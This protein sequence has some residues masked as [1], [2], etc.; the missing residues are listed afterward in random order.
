MKKILLLDVDGTLIHDR[1]YRHAMVAAAQHVCR[2]RALPTHAPTDHE[3]NA[4]HACGFS[5][6]WDS[7]PFTVGINLLLAAN[8]D[9]APPDFAAWAIKTK[10]FAGLPN[11][12]A[13]EALKREAPAK[14]HDDLHAL[15]DEVKDPHTSETTRLLY[16]FVLGAPRF[17]QHY[18]VPADV[19]TDSMLERMDV[20][21]IDD[22]SRETIFAHAS[23]IYT[24]RPSLPPEGKA[25]LYQTPEAEIAMAQLQLDPQR[26]PVMG[27]GPMQ[28]LVDRCGGG[29]WDYAKPARVQPIAAMLAATGMP[30]MDATL[31]AFDA[32][33][34]HGALHP[35]RFAARTFRALRPLDGATVIVFEDNAG[36]VR[37]AK[38]AA[39]VLA[40]HDIRVKV[41]GYGIAKDDAKRAA[42]GAVCEALFDDVNAALRAIPSC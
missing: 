29:M 15:L 10:D 3:I 41:I 30:V 28:W 20:P 39:Q 16:N 2:R 13:R 19:Q 38:E 23:V 35:L 5:N 6:E 1:G 42:L 9:D 4:M 27:L 36:G 11:E 22:A 37:A 26:V 40:Q 17:E 8:G 18:G 31:A 32:V 12:R 34:G 14:L 24:A 21:L 33:Q 7:V 25:G